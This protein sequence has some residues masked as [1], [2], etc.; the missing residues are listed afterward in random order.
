[1]KMKVPTLLLFAIATSAHAFAPL[2]SRQS[3]WKI[4]QTVRTSSGPVNGH[5]ASNE[6]QV[7]EYLG[8]PFAK[9][10]VGELR[11]AVPVAYNGTVT[12]NG[13]NFVSLNF[14]RH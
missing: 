10:P 13:T 4:G 12:L 9:P 3:N 1:M 11:F 5:A 6:S 8:I 14:F 7:S 2:Q